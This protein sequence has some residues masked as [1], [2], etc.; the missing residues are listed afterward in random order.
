MAAALATV[1]AAEAHAAPATVSD[2][3]KQPPVAAD[4]RIAYGAEPAQVID[5]FLPKRRGPHPVVVLIH[6]GC[7]TV[8]F[9]GI[10]QM[11]NMAGDLVKQG[12]A[13]WNVEYR[14]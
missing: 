3:M 1:L 14:R 9:G 13:V 4:H 10:A 5:L 11:H 8:H 2:Y 7:W 6:G 12:I